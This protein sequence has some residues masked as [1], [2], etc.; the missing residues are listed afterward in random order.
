[1][2]QSGLNIFPLF[3]RSLTEIILYKALKSFRNSKRKM[4]QNCTETG[5]QLNLFWKSS[6]QLAY[7]TK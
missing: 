1:M 7:E 6:C 5:F 2:P 3:H 4:G